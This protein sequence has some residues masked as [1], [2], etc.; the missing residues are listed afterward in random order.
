[1]ELFLDEKNRKFSTNE[2]LYYSNFI[3]LMEGNNNNTFR[4]LFSPREK[5]MSFHLLD[6]IPDFNRKE[7]IDNYNNVIDV[8]KFFIS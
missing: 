8:N 7:F 3:S 5:I 1:M 6:I 4:I 2:N